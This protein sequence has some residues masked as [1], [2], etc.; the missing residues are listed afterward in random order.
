MRLALTLAALLA[1]VA[2]ATG[3]IWL[4]S[5]ANQSGHGIPT[6]LVACGAGALDF[7]DACGTTQYLVILR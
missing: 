3:Q 4:M 1:L 7:T 6:P 5:P 2:T